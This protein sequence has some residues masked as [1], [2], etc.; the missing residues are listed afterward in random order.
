MEDGATDT[1]FT[2][3]GMAHTSL[4]KWS[5]IVVENVS[6]F[7]GEFWYVAQLNGLAIF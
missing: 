1:L 2:E 6:L 7:S 4:L 5:S 3:N